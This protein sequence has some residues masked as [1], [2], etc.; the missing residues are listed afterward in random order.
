[1][2]AQIN[3]VHARLYPEILPEA[4]NVTAVAGGTSIASYS[5][6][7]QAGYIMVLNSLYTDVGAAADIRVDQDS[8]YATLE[9]TCTATSD[10]E[11]RQVEIPCIKSLD[12]WAVGA[13][14]VTYTAFTTKIMKPTVFDKIKYGYPLS[15]EE[16]TL[17]DQFDIRKNFQAGI[18]KQMDSPMYQRLYEVIDTITVVAGSHTRVGPLI[19]VPAG[20]KAVIL[21]IGTNEAV[22]PGA[23][24]DTFITINRDS[25]LSYVKL[26]TDA[27]PGLNHN[28]ECYIPGI[29]TVEVILE[30]V[31]G[32][33]AMPVRYTYSISDITI[34]EKIRWGLPLST[35]EASIAQELDLYGIAAAGLM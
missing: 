33:V 15:A 30:S 21:S 32:I 19:N 12:L 9:S 18:L 2:T 26:D 6:F 14:I 27:M 31:T 11:R 8:S 23:G 5:G 24:N 28:V 17:A 7:T 4:I 16:I 1:M 22:A 29:D 34:L 35:T 13:G 3:P 10:R 20:K 25:D